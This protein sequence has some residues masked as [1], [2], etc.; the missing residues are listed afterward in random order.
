MI[1]VAL[2]ITLFLAPF[3]LTAQTISS[4]HAEEVRG[5]IIKSYEGSVV[6]DITIEEQMIKARFLHD[7][8]YKEAIFSPH[9]VWQRTSYHATLPDLTAEA[10]EVL[11]GVAYTD[12]EIKQIEVIEQPQIKMYRVEMDNYIDSKPISII[13]TD[14]GIEL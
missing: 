6:T 11:S 7:N 13:V 9:G 3:L 14:S 1:R 12:Y 8:I 4:S 5:V 2:L 10:K